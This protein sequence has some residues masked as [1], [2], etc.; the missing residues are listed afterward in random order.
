[1]IMGA[2]EGYKKLP[3]PWK[4]TILR[5]NKENMGIDLEAMARE[6]TSVEKK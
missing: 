1:M 6:M 5:V 4:E 3:A 2:K